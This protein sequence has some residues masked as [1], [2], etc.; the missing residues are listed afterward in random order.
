MQPTLLRN[1]I[2]YLHV[3]DMATE[4]YHF[5]QAGL[6]PGRGGCPALSSQSAEG[7]CPHCGGSSIAVVESDICCASCG[8]VLDRDL[9][10]PE[11]PPAAKLNLYQATSIGG[12]RV[13]LDC[14]RHFHEGDRDMSHISNA[15]VKLN[16]PMYTSQEA[17]STYHKV[18]RKQR[19]AVRAARAQGWNGRVP[20]SGRQRRFSRAHTAAFAMHDACRKYGIPK[21]ESEIVEAVMMNFGIKQKFTM[22]KAYSLSEFVAQDA[23][24]ECGRENAEYYLRLLLSDLQSSIGPGQVYD[25]IVRRAFW[26]LQMISD[27]R[28]NSRA[29]RALDLAKQGAVLNVRI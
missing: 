29:R 2:S 23:G 11:C 24:V 13:D 20:P 12:G 10:A 22:L 5:R 9:Q 16:L 17:N 26:N 3:L 21:S 27:V 4:P 28:Q 8:A 14:A 15:C 1:M 18:A 6:P 7:P 25:G 19:S